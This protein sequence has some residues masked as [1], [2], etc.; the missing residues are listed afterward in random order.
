[1]T[2][3]V[4][5]DLERVEAL[6]GSLL[7]AVLQSGD[8][9]YEA[10][11][12]VH[13]GLIDRPGEPPGEISLEPGWIVAIAGIVLMFYGGAKRSSESERPRKPPGVL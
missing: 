12:L 1:M 10:A 9:R 5:L 4:G 7:G 8:E 13:N 11:R 3:A 6:S 2:S